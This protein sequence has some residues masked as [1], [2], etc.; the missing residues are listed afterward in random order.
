[1]L[2]VHDLLERQR[3]SVLF[4]VSEALFYTAVTPLFRGPSLGGLSLVPLITVIFFICF[5][6]E[7]LVAGV[8]KTQEDTL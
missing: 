8:R 1:M 4:S 2:L 5:S 7:F 3:V 6:R